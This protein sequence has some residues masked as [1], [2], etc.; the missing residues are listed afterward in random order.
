MS[1]HQ[2]LPAGD[3]WFVLEPRGDPKGEPQFEPH[4]VIGW[5]VGEFVDPSWEL[6]WGFFVDPILADRLLPP[7]FLL[8]RPDGR[9][10]DDD[11]REFDSRDEA[12]DYLRVE[13]R[14]GP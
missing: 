13:S 14:E 5:A 11:G 12:L 7:Y 6:S 4:P 9:I 10:T 8:Q 2:V 1:D 3:G